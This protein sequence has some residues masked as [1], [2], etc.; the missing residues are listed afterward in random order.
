MIGGF[1]RL[2]QR[3][4]DDVKYVCPY[5][6]ELMNDFISVPNKEC[7]IHEKRCGTLI[8][9]AQHRKMVHVSSRFNKIFF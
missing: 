8:D 6:K 3:C 9:G 5:R 2:A 7:G 1:A 4:A